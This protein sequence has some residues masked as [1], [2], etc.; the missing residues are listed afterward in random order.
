MQLMQRAQA[1]GVALALA[2]S[3]SAFAADNTTGLDA[4][5]HVVNLRCKDTGSG[6][7]ACTNTVANSS[8]AIID[9][10]TAQLQDAGN[11]ALSEIS[12]AVG[13]IDQGAWSGT[14]DGSAIAIAKYAAAKAEA[15]R[16]ALTGTLNVAGTVG[17]TGTV[18]VTCPD[19]T[20]AG[21]GGGAGHVIVDTA[22]TTPVTGTITANIGTTNGVALDAS[23]GG[24]SAAVAGTTGASTTNGFLRYLRDW[25]QAH[26]G[27]QARATSLGVALSTEDAANLQKVADAASDLTTPQFVKMDHTTPGASDEVRVAANSS[28][29]TADLIQADKSVPINISTPTTTQLVALS[30]GKAIYVTS[31]DVIAAGTGNITLEYSPVSNCVTGA[32][33][34]TGPYSL[35]AQAGIAKGTGLA[36]VLVVPAS[37]ALCALTTAAVQMSGSVSYTQF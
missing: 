16:T 7:L 11:A 2:L 20:C 14:G 21:S 35:T 32:T 10:A 6:I 23:L 5:G 34:L 26:I 31:W 25:F 24:A 18:V 27:G 12:D 37:N 17:V 3:G 36:P 33:P 29:A 13:S 9:P 19:G 1:L 28:G 4:A 15:M 8:G 30:S 22:P